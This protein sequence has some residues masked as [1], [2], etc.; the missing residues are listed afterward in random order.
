MLNALLDKY[1]D[2]GVG[3]IESINVLK[4]KPLDQLGTPLEIVK[5]AFGSKKEYEQAITELEI[6]LYSDERISA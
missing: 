1:A 6:A 5:T 4:V 2:V 3:E